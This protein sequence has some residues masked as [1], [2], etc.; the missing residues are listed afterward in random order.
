MTAQLI[1]FLFESHEVRITDQHGEPWFILR[2]LL[3]AMGSKT[4]TTNALDSIKQGLGEGYSNDIPLQTAGGVQQAIIVSEPAATYLLARSNTEEGRKLNRFIHTEV[5]PSIRKTGSYALPAAKPT[6]TPD[7]LL[8][9]NRRAK[10]TLSLYMTAAKW[11]GTDA[12]MARAIAVDAV[13]QQTGVDLQPLLG[14][15]AIEENPMTPTELGKPLNWTGR[16]MNARLALAG[17]QDRNENGEWVPTDKGKPYCTVNP[18][19]APHSEHTGY[20]VLWYRTVLALFPVPAK[21]E[22]V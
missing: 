9:K 16:A 4:T 8:L 15:N 3:D 6:A 21:E 7:D 11:L 1:P 18:Y 10:S 5:L 12:P 22:A 20:R 2:D 19:K 17:L 14:G 13:K